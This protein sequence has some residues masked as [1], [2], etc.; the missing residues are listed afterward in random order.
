MTARG[1]FQL[2]CIGCKHPVV[3][4]MTLLDAPDH[5]VSCSECG[6]KYGFHEDSLKRQ[7]KKF[8]SLCAQIKESEEILGSSAISVEVGN[9]QVQIPFKLLLTRLKSTLDLSV[10]G[11]KMVITFRA[12]PTSSQKG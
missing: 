12:E 8:A 4:S 6:K 5:L 7:L 1:S 11:K 3:F 2:D 9:N 10:Q